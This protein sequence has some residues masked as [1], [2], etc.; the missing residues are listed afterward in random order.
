MD[1]SGR[2]AVVTGG[3]QGIGRA[4]CDALAADGAA[5]AVV[6]LNLEGATETAERIARAGGTA[7]ALHVDVSEQ[8]STRA[9]AAAVAERLGPATILVNNAAIYHSMRMDPVTEVEPDYWRRVFAVNV[10]GALLTVQAFAPQM[11]AAGWG[12]VVNQ[13]SVAAYGAAGV[14]S[15]TKLALISLTQC[16]AMELGRHGITVNAIAPGPIDTEATQVVVGEERTQGMLARAAIPQ[17]HGPEV[18]VGTLRHLVSD[19]AA[20]VTGQTLLVDGGIT[21]RL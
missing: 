11:I 3:A 9:L 1:L 21:R 15:V 4:Y 2:V 8:E 17:L 14:Y 5:V 7:V 20:W 19:G 16:Q 12:R 13:T 6:D 18:L 10:D